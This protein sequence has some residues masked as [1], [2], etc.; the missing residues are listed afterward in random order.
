MTHSDE[1]DPSSWVGRPA[2]QAERINAHR[3]RASKVAWHD[4]T[5]D[6]N[7]ETDVDFSGTDHDAGTDAAHEAAEAGAAPSEQHQAVACLTFTEDELERVIAGVL[8]QNDRWWQAELA[9]ERAAF[10]QSISERLTVA[11]TACTQELTDQRQ[12]VTEQIAT[13]LADVTTNIIQ[14]RRSDII[15][16]ELSR[17]I[18][19]HF[20]TIAKPVT[21]A[22][23][24][25]QSQ[26]PAVET[27]LA[28][29]DP[30]LTTDITFDV[31]IDSA[32]ADNQIL[33]NAEHRWF[34]VSV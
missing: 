4:L 32:M 22:V 27:M 2:D 33:M 29:L 18:E 1:F 16:E 19:D 23:F 14:L 10:E 8:R 7:V 31:Q 24:V 30:A 15:R 9:Q 13:M 5:A 28:E 21:L 25:S 11:V 17:L 6:P 3:Q 34:E 12:N 20:D 26:Q